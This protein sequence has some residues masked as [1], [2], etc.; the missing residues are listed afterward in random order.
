MNFT[1][2]DIE[3]YC[4]VHSTPVSK[5]ADEL[6]QYTMSS[7]HGSQMLVGKLEAAV[8]QFLIQLGN[9]KHI[10]ELGTYTGYSALIMAEALPHDGTVTT[11]DINPETSKIAKSFWSKSTHGTKINSIL[12][13]GPEILKTLTQKFDLIFI[14]ADKNNYPF[15]LQWGLKH[16]SDNGFIVTDNTLWYGKV[17]ES[18]PEDKQTVS[19]QE[20]NTIAKELK[21]YQKVL[22][23][24]RDGMY[25]IKPLR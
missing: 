8:L 22:M 25:L 3:Q 14:D 4:I 17:L 18:H 16:L 12:G 21:S 1:Q 24:I 6:Q 15:Y 10:L 9:A 13:S 7:V 23:P 20:H 2:K 11:V 5:T 19:I